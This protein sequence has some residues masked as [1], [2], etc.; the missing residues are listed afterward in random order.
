MSEAVIV[1]LLSLFGTLIGS[2][3]G[4]LTASRMTNYRLEQLERKVEKHNQLI[5]RMALAER[6]IQALQTAILE[7]E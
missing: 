1:A 7:R 2:L 3:G 6:D 4:V 5:E